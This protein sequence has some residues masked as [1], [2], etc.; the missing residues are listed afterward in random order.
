MALVPMLS[1]FDHT[2][3]LHLELQRVFAQV[4]P[5]FSLAHLPNSNV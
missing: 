3:S 2:H 4:L 5:V 1:T